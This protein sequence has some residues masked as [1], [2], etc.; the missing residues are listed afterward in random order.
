LFAI[1]GRP[2]PRNDNRQCSQTSPTFI[3]YCDVLFGKLDEG[4]RLEL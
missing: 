4:E 3:G 1:G 2:L